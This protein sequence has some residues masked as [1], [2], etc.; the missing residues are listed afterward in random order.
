M[1]PENQRIICLPLTAS[2]FA[3]NAD[4]SRYKELAPLI[5]ADRSCD[6]QLSPFMLMYRVIRNRL[7]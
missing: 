7:R 1:S 6:K 3:V 5:H 2:R 4:K